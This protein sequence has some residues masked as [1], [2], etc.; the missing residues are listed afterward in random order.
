AR[1]GI[2]VTTTP[3]PLASADRA[4]ADLAHDRVHGAAVLHVTDP[5]LTVSAPDPSPG[6][7]ESGARR[8]GDGS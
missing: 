3:Y 7:A 1:I 6:G 4:L 8:T 2:R 5:D